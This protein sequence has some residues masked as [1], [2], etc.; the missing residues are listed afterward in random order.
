MAPAQV[1][2]GI[3]VGVCAGAIPTTAAT[4]GNT[5]EGAAEPRQS[6]TTRRRESANA[7]LLRPRS[8]PGSCRRLRGR[9]ALPDAG[10]RS[11]E[12]VAT[13]FAR[14]IK[15][16]GGDGRLSGD[17]SCGA[18]MA[19]GL[20]VR[21]ASA[22]AV[23]CDRSSGVA[24]SAVESARRF[25]DR[26]APGSHFERS[27]GLGADAR[28]FGERLL[29]EAA[30]RRR[31]RRTP[32]VTAGI[33][34]TGLAKIRAGC[35]S[36]VLASYAMALPRCDRAHRRDRLRRAAG[37]RSDRDR[38]NVS[39]AARPPTNGSPTV[40][41]SDECGRDLG[42]GS[43]CNDCKTIGSGLNLPAGVATTNGPGHNFEKRRSITSPITA[44][45]ES[46]SSRTHARP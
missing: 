45:N 26:C 38:R 15:R 6:R 13:S 40:I 35:Y 29:R 19:R 8:R 36:F 1:G 46:S 21:A 18:P 14:P 33:S 2:D 11:A 44:I 28:A 16:V 37:E 41:T 3:S 17:V 27:D 42:V 32:N 12:A 24:F 7:A 10:F 9:R 23:S 43:P 30:T 25:L 34:Y 4:V 31:R 5:A 20:R 22:K 39:S